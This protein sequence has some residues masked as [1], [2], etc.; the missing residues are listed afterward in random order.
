MKESSRHVAKNGPGRA[1]PA[2][3]APVDGN[4]TVDGNERIGREA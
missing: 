2:V 3:P 1:V 4:P